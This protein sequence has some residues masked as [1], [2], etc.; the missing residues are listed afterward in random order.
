MKTYKVNEKV[1]YHG[2]GQALAE[3]IR[4]EVISLYYLD[5]IVDCRDW[6]EVAD[7][8]NL[9]LLPDGEDKVRFFI[10]A[11]RDNGQKLTRGMCSCGEFVV[12]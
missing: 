3:I 2:E 10:E 6:T 12:L 7:D 9:H 11:R 4:D 1:G 5:S 8:E